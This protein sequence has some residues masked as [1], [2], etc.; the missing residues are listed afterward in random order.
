MNT[1]LVV[2]AIIGGMYL[3]ISGVIFLEKRRSII[4]IGRRVRYRRV[5]LTGVVSDIYSVLRVLVGLAYLVGGIAYW[6][7]VISEETIFIMIVLPVLLYIIISSFASY[8]R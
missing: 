1:T 5:M 6:A 8:I 3:I 7:G 2:I 4:V